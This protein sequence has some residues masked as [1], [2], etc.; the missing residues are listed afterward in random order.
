[1]PINNPGPSSSTV[2]NT[3]AAPFAGVYSY[4]QLPSASLYAAGTTA[5]TTDQGM[6]VSN[7]SSWTSTSIT[8]PVGPNALDTIPI[9]GVITHSYGTNTILKYQIITASID[10]TA[11]NITVK[12]QLTFSASVGDTIRVYGLGSPFD[13]IWRVT[14]LSQPGGTN[15]ATYTYNN[16]AAVGMSVVGAFNVPVG[17]AYAYYQGSSG[18]G[19]GYIGSGGIVWAMILSKRAF[20][21]PA[22]Y[23]YTYSGGTIIGGNDDPG[24]ATYVTRMLAKSPLPQYVYIDL[25][26]ND[27]TQT[28]ATYSLANLQSVVTASMTRLLSAGIIPVMMAI[29]PVQASASYSL[30]NLQINKKTKQYNKWLQNYCRQVGAIYVDSNSLSRDVYSTNAAVGG[31]LARI[32]KDFVHV[33]G[34]GGKKDGTAINAVLS[35]TLPPNGSPA[36][37]AADAIDSTYNVTGSI[38]PVINTGV[39]S[40]PGGIFTQVVAD[41][42]LTTTAVLFDSV[43][44]KAI[45]AG[46]SAVTA[47]V[48]KSTATGPDGSLLP[49]YELVLKFGAGTG[50]KNVYI[51]VNNA[52]G[53]ITTGSSTY[54]NGDIVQAE[55]E[56]SI[57]ASGVTLTGSPVYQMPGLVLAEKIEYPA[58]TSSIQNFSCFANNSSTD[59]AA[60]TAYD[61]TA[62]GATTD[63]AFDGTVA[64][65]IV[66]SR[67]Y[68]ITPASNYVQLY[69]QVGILS[70]TLG[71][72]PFTVI[73]R[74]ITLR[75]IDPVYG[76]PF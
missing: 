71:A 62:F 40:V 63:I 56:V 36:L 47:G 14:A 33:G 2:A 76:E 29:R 24:L 50:P 61:T 69:A 35:K 52:N 6:V 11:G 32:Y 55:M 58:S 42:A 41:T 31:D 5:W 20:C 44:V 21:V 39:A 45:G 72:G 12:T 1:M 7:G 34:F 59:Y 46:T 54:S 15:Y 70:G 27:M 30:T 43:Y 25:G 48:Q 13:G 18:S 66:T 8:S 19:A 53:T 49:G 22:S 28:T 4:A 10:D 67:T 64:T 75:K 57:P 51:Y 38:V 60:L 73:I 68:S 9:M 23:L 65:P 16:P 26:I 74:S 37:T 3:S 17:S